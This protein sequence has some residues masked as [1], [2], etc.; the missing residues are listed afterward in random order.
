MGKSKKNLI[1][2]AVCAIIWTMTSLISI[3]KKSYDDSM[4]L[5]VMNIL[6]TILWYIAFISELNRSKE[7]NG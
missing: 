5:F 2:Y 1:L 4:F 3:V 7:N 6:C